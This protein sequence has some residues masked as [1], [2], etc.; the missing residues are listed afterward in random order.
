MTSTLLRWTNQCWPKWFHTLKM[1]NFVSM[2]L[3]WTLWEFLFSWT[4]RS[5]KTS[6]IKLYLYCT[7]FLQ[8]FTFL[9]FVNALKIGNLSKILEDP[10]IRININLVHA[11]GSFM[12]DDDDNDDKYYNCMYYSWLTLGYWES[13]PRVAMLEM[14][15]L[16]GFQLCWTNQAAKCIKFMNPEIPQKIQNGAI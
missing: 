6:S 3:V 4:P 7:I 12:D 8:R 1:A 2:P 9:G 13:H 16:Y 15:L 10:C 14:K 5:L 11:I